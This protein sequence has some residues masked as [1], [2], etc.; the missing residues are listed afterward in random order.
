MLLM[1]RLI[2]R[3]L[4]L[5]VAAPLLARVLAEASR[6]VDQ[7]RGPQ[8]LANSMRHGSRM[9]NERGRHRRRW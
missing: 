3:Y 4:L 9:L 6:R 1:R 8:W 2:K 7:R 5:L